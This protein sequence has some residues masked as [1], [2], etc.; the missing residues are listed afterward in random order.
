MAAIL[1]IDWSLEVKQTV[2]RFERAQPGLRKVEQFIV[3]DILVDREKSKK[4][5]GCAMEQEADRGNY[6]SQSG[7]EVG[8]V[9]HGTHPLR[10]ID[11]PSH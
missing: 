5:Q 9:V 4:E 6:N 8:W 1:P 11:L 10:A 7:V 3:S 2:G